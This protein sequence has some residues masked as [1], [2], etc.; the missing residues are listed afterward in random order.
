MPAIDSLADCIL[1]GIDSLADCILQGIDSLADCNFCKGLTLD[2]LAD[3]KLPGMDSLANFEL[4]MILGYSSDKYLGIFF[5]GKS[6]DLCLLRTKNYL[7][8]QKSIGV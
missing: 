1:Q 6:K 3:C 7:F 4:Q 8:L 5:V 2:S